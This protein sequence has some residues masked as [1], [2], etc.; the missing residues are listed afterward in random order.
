MN[1]LN[2]SINQK[3]LT[4]RFGKNL[5]IQK[6]LLMMNPLRYIAF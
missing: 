5:R 3:D 1:N 6:E 4:I 2:Y